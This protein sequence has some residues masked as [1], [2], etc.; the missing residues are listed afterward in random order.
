M[1]N[2]EDH[3]DE[4]CENL[5]YRNGRL[6]ASKTPEE[7]EQLW[8]NNLDGFQ[9]EFGTIVSECGCFIEVDKKDTIKALNA[10]FAAFSKPIS[11][12]IKKKSVILS[13]YLS[14]PQDM[15]YIIALKPLSDSLK[16]SEPKTLPGL[17]EIL[18]KVESIQMN[19]D[20]LK[21]H[22]VLCKGL[23]LQ[24][25]KFKEDIFRE[26]VE[27]RETVATT[28]RDNLSEDLRAIIKE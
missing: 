17:E 25:E 21:D 14:Q 12:M 20:C 1:L 3:I 5:H 27:I 2:F 24:L 18:K 22:K 9:R 19:V 23:I 10:V 16:S 8:R 26:T 11:A 7:I 6:D 15:S 4:V 13:Q 28:I